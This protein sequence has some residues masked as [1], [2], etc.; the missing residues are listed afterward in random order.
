ME[1]NNMPMLGSIAPRFVA[2]STFGPLKITDYIGKWVI[3]FSHPASFTPVCTTEIMSF[4]KFNDEFKKRNCELLG[5]SVDSAPSHLAWVKDIEKN[6]G[7]HIPFPLISDSDRSISNMYGMIPN[8]SNSTHTVRNVFILDPNQMIRCILI[9]PMENGRNISEILRMVDALQITDA[10]NVSTPANW[11]PGMAT[12]MPSPQ[13]YSE[14]M[15]NIKMNNNKNC[16]DWYLCFNK[17]NN[18][19]R[20]W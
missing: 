19:L 20:R 8:N 11:V 10:E 16:M 6:S 7:T 17:E 2:N 3:L 9:Y 13:N 18:D 12:I 4:A 5:L 15:D 1:K 14:L